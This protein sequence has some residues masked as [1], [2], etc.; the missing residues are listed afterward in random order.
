MF[1]EEFDVA[2]YA[3]DCTAYEYKNPLDEVVMCLERDAPCLLEWDQNN[4]LKPNPDK[5][6]LL[7]NKGKTKK[8]LVLLLTLN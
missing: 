4:Y 7:L 1:T 5:H 2:H 6:H 8:S 3:D